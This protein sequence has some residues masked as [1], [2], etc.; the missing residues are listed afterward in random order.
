MDK[1]DEDNN[2]KK[3]HNQQLRIDVT[4]HL[5]ATAKLFAGNSF[6]ALII[7]DFKGEVELLSKFGSLE[8]GKL[9]NAKSITVEFG[10][11]YIESAANTKLTIKYSKADIKKI[12]GVIKGN[13]DFCNSI[14]LVVDAN[15]KS[16]DL[17]CNYTSTHLEV[18]KM[19]RL[20][21]LL[22]LKM[23]EPAAVVLLR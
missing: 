16:I 11:A 6:G 2:G 4:V 5:P 7:K 1:W 8:T 17:K 10:K 19:L 20:I 23:P 15:V 22:K 13:F 18:E 21:I 3:A 9:T 12:E 14:D